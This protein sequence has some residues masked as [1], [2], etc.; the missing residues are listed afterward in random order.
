MPEALESVPWS[1]VLIRATGVTA[2]GLLT[3]VVVWGLALRIMRSKRTPAPR[4]ISIHR[5]LGTLALLVVL[6]HMG[7][8][9]IDPFMPFT[10]VEIF[11]PFVAPWRP[12]AVAL[13]IVAFWVMIPAWVLGRLRR[14]FGDRWFTRA[15]VVAYLAWP[16][17]TAHYVLAGTDA[18]ASWSIGLIIAGTA[19]V[20][21]G[22]LAQ[23]SIKEPESVSR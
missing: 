16:L 5:W 2:W 3:A 8:L 4:V 13:G 20:V 19:L 23:T 1:W 11:V 14:R 15:H 21:A 6:V 9:L 12:L 17:A 18:L 10:I 7:L 22:L